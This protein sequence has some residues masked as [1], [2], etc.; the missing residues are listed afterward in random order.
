M[1]AASVPAVS[2]PASPAAL[3][4]VPVAE[5]DK[6]FPEQ[7]AADFAVAVPVPAMP[8]AVSVPVM[9]SAAHFPV[10]PVPAQTPVPPVLTRPK[11]FSGNRKSFCRKRIFLI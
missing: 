7:L 6:Y 11:A 8:A 3:T 4:A 10:L 1:S 9:P 2:A 5:V